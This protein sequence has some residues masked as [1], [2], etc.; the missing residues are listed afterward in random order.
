MIFVAHAGSSVILLTERRSSKSVKD[1][2]AFMK[3]ILKKC[4][5]ELTMQYSVMLDV[6]KVR[7]DTIYFEE[8]IFPGTN[9]MLKKLFPKARGGMRLSVQI[10]KNDK[11]EKVVGA[12]LVKELGIH[13][14][15][16]VVTN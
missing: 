1:P 9:T 13:E 7:G 16:R 4:K 11:T 5:E 14:S 15:V 3:R 10:E 6:E 12:R 8:E 2:L